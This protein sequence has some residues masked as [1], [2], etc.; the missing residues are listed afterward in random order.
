MKNLSLLVWLS[1]LGF[2]VVVPLVGFIWLGIW[3][4]SQFGWGEWVLWAGIGLGLISAINGLRHSLK[5]LI[6]FTRKNAGDTPPPVSYN[7]HD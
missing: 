1:Q 3:L 4:R 5:M 6:R 2:S 7:D